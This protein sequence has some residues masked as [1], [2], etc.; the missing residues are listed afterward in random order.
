MAHV[1]R[2]TPQLV[3][4]VPR[5]PPP[6]ATTGPKAALA[7]DED[8]ATVLAAIHSSRPASGSA[9]DEFWIF[10][11]GSLIWNPGFSFTDARPARAH[12]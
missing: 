9:R 3:A 11:Y 8:H 1:L 4:R 10:A 6:P 5:A 2:L 12:G 7:G